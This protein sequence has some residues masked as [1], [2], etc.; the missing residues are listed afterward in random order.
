M[1]CIVTQKLDVHVGTDTTAAKLT[2]NDNEKNSKHQVNLR[3]DICHFHLY[4]LLYRLDS[5][6]WYVSV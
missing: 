6:P 4:C 2:Y 3:K 1:Y 5:L